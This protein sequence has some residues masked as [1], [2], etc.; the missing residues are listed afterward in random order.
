MQ[1]GN[2]FVSGLNVLDEKS[3]IHSINDKTYIF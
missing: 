1:L 3:F 2:L